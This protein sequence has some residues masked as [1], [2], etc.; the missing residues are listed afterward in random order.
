ME[1]G[2]APQ[3]IVDLADHIVRHEFLILNRS[4]STGPDIHWRRDY[5]GGIETGPVYFRRVPF[6]D[7][8]CA[9]DHKMIWELNR[10]QHLLVLA[11]AYLL[12]G[13]AR[14]RDEAWAQLRS[15]ID[16]NPFH[17]GIN[18]ASALEVAIR[19]L[20]WIWLDQ[21][22]GF[23][24]PASL[25]TRWLHTAYLHGCHLA[26]NLSFYFSP[27]NHLVGEA[28]GLHALGV[29]FAGLP[30]AQ[31]WQQLGDRVVREQMDRQIRA[32]GSNF[33]QSTYYQ[34]YLI[35]MFALHAMLAGTDAAYLAKL[36]RMVDF[37]DAVTGPSG[38][39]PMLGDDDG[40]HL[41]TPGLIQ[42]PS[43]AGKH[44]SRLFPDAGL[45]VMVCG[46]THAVIDA[47]SF[48]ALNSG[49]SHSD[50]LSIIVRRG[51]E[52]IL[53]DPGTYTYTGEPEWRDRFRGSAAHN[54]VRID[55]RDQA[56][57]AGP[58]Q[59]VHKPQVEV[60]KWAPGS[61]RDVLEAECRYFEFTHR[62]RVEFQK[63]N[64]F[65]ITDHLDGPPGDHDVE[66]FWH[67]GSLAARSKLALPADA[68]LLESWRSTRF[69]EKHPAPIVR[70]RRRG[71]LPTRL[72]VRIDLT[73]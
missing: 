17:R 62:R 72:E 57:V 8:Q 54:T 44:E 42:R 36:Q 1:A 14:Y 40:G 22:I 6:L 67:L 13:E 70:V 68:E 39:P 28:V 25:R 3:N 64:L 63:P 47:G 71:R 2:L 19:A 21:M 46:D 4:I 48:G 9:G 38:I 50:T 69:G 32:D 26:N 49:H 30:Q 10:H 53:I 31:Q 11:A 43:R 41:L 58:F 35:D 7:T 24:M 60:L 55:G 29:F 73:R 18:W 45:A 34:G 61:D 51:A 27:N 16:A 20:S 65:L 23:E 52:E 66:H 56:V 12:T 59:W 37:L 15:W 33:E 5:V